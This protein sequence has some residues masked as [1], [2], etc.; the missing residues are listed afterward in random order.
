MPVPTEK[1]VERSVDGLQKIYAVVV[2]LAI[3]QAVMNFLKD[4]NDFGAFFTAEAWNAMSAIAALLLTVVPFYHGMNRHL[5]R[6]YLERDAGARHGALLLDFSAFF[7][8]SFVLLAVSW[9]I[10]KGPL[11]FFFLGVLLVG[12]VIWG[13]MSHFIH[14][15]GGQSTVLR[16][17]AINM[18]AVVLGGLVWFTEAFPESKKVWVFL[19]IAFLRTVLDY[20]FGW[21]FYFPKFSTAEA[22]KQ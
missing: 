15:A 9:S 12:D 10:R 21:D 3:S 22:A 6:S 4:R 13:I 7:L 2:A 14:Y 11:A 20:K 1:I 5:E 8:E 16:W 17:S 19:V 18:G